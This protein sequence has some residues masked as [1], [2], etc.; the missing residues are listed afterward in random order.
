MLR[1][2]LLASGLIGGGTAA[3][4]L[5]YRRATYYD[6]G[7][8]GALRAALLADRKDD[9]KLAERRFHDALHSSTTQNG[10][11]SVPQDVILSLKLLL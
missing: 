1:R 3:A 2:F 5:L 11:Q 4:Y 8:R 9:F 7:T 6:P 10:P